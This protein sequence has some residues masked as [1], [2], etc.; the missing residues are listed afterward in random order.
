MKLKEVANFIVFC[1]A[2]VRWVKYLYSQFKFWAQRGHTH[3]EGWKKALKLGKNNQ[4]YHKF[5]N[6][7]EGLNW[8]EIISVGPFYDFYDGSI[9]I[10]METQYKVTSFCHDISG[11]K[12]IIVIKTTNT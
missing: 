10:P 4:N 12:P 7:L 8:H 5:H 1:L 2:V 9:S 11:A 6:L 3:F